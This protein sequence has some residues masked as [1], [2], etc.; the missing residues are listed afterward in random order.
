MIRLDIC[1]E[2]VANLSDQNSHR[3]ERKNDK[4]FVMGI[5]IESTVKFAKK[6][7]GKKTPP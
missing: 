2:Y 1:L 7:L 5:A 6:D 3:V 4:Q